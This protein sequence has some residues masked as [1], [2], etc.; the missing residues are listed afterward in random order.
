MISCS[1][2]Q[3]HSHLYRH[4]VKACQLMG[5]KLPA[6]VQLSQVA[7]LGSLLLLFLLAPLVPSFL[8]V[9]YFY[10]LFNVIVLGLGIQAGLLRGGSV[11]G[12]ITTTSSTPRAD[13]RSPSDQTGTPI[14]IGASPFQRP[15]SVQQPSVVEQKSAADAPVVSVFGASI[16]L[17]VIDLKIILPIIELKTKTKDVV[18]TLMKK[19]PSTASIFFLSALDGG[20]VGGEEQAYEEEKKDSNKVDVDGDVTMSRQELFANT[21]RFI[22]MFRKHLSIEKQ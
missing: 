15:R 14:S 18:L 7:K 2:Q 21:E 12:V 6:D 16:P 17:P 11:I 8:R 19:C 9:S 13:D 5:A 3:N 1:K 22:G 4:V 20:Q 10:F